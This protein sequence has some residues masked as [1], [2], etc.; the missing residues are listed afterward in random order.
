VLDAGEIEASA[1]VRE[2]LKQIPLGLAEI[3]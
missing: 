2:Q 1:L 3:G